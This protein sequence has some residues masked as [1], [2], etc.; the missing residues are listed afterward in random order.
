MMTMAWRMENGVHSQKKERGLRLR[1]RMYS[2][3]GF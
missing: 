1:E 3:I 2:D